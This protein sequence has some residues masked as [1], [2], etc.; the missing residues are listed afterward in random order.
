MNER[1]VLR[2]TRLHS[3]GPEQE[4]PK[5]KKKKN[6]LLQGAIVTVGAMALTV[7]AIHASDSFKNNDALIAGVAGSQKQSRC[8]SEMVFVSSSGGGFCIDRYEAS[9]SKPCPH[10]DPNNQFETSDNISQLLC[11]PV[12]EENAPPWVN[13][14]QSQAMELCARVGKHLASNAEWYRAALGTPDR[15]ESDNDSQGCVLGRIGVSRGEKTGKHSAC[16]SSAGAFDMVG[17]VWEWVDGNISDGIYQKRELPSEGYVIEAD[18][19]GVP[20]R[21]ATTSSEVFHGD[22][23]YVK[24]DGVNGMLRGGFWNL[25]EK[26]GVATINATVPMS[27]VGSAVGFRCAK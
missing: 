4:R 15:V 21:V 10:Q 12:S 3:R 1:V 13:I 23:F 27:F 2:P 22:Y 7:L 19:D 14:P 26:A 16:V 17:N 5:H 11:L 8:P 6:K 9:A 18:V 20:V 24:A 25:S